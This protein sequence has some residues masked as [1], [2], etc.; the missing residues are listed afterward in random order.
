MVYPL[1]F[2][3]NTSKTSTIFQVESSFKDMLS[4]QYTL[5][6]KERCW[7]TF[8]KQ[9]TWSVSILCWLRAN[10]C[11]NNGK[12]CRKKCLKNTI[13]RQVDLTKPLTVHETNIEILHINSRLTETFTYG[14]SRYRCI[15]MMKNLLCTLSTHTPTGSRRIVQKNTTFVGEICK[16]Q[17]H[18]IFFCLSSTDKSSGVT[19]FA[20]HQ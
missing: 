4:I 16:I 1:C 20:E 10:N 9:W 7:Q 14:L 19:L 5:Y 18:L 13:L 3:F 15:G 6:S 17:P 8:R 2:P 12:K 11:R